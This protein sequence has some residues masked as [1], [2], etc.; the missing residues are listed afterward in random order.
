MGAEE[1]VLWVL[2]ELWVLKGL[3]VVG[4]VQGVVG[5]QGVGVAPKVG[6]GR[7]RGVWG[8]RGGAQCVGANDDGIGM[9]RVWGVSPVSLGSAGVG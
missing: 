4:G 2:G 3:W 9:L 6:R 8:K 7:A 1:D 5:A